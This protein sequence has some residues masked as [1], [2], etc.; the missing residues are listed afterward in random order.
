MEQKAES[1]AD[2]IL[3]E[4]V[5]GLGECVLILVAYRIYWWLTEMVVCYGPDWLVAG[6]R[7]PRGR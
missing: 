2:H 5:K 6:S 3:S 1:K 4:V 7:C